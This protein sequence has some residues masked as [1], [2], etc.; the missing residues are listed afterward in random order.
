MNLNY[1]F[2]VKTLPSISSQQDSSRVS[3]ERWT[4]FFYPS[5]L[6]PLRVW[7]GEVGLALLSPFPGLV[8]LSP[9]LFRLF[10]VFVNGP[11]LWKRGP[12]PSCWL[13]SLPGHR[14]C[15]S[16]RYPSYSLSYDGVFV[17]PLGTT[18]PSTHSFLE[19]VIVLRH[20]LFLLTKPTFG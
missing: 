14:F 19:K 3:S 11:I 10:F 8:A 15:L 1:H 9:W 16:G 20:K 6:S 13:L 17:V 7:V 5:P 4:V 12:A 2:R 18:E